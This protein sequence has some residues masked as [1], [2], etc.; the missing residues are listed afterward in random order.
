MRGEAR[1]DDATPT[2]TVDG[3]TEAAE[4]AAGPTQAELAELMHAARARLDAGDADGALGFALAAVKFSNGGNLEAIGQTLTAAKVKAAG[5]RARVMQQYPGISE[6]DASMMAAADAVRD[7]MLAKTS[8]LGDAGHSGLLRGA[9]EDGSSVVCIRCGQ[10]IAIG[11][12]EAHRT[13]WCPQI[14]DG[15][16]TEDD[17]EKLQLH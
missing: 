13:L 9:M 2:P 7:D 1:G 8:V 6:E 17:V 12:T 16:V 4:A 15:E 10:L 5:D 11:R 14:D 3:A